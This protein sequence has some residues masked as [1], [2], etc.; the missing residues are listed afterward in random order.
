MVPHRTG[1]ARPLV[2]HTVARTANSSLHALRGRLHD[3]RVCRVHAPIFQLP[4]SWVCRV[5]ASDARLPERRAGSATTHASK[6]PSRRA[7]SQF[8]FP[9][10]AKLTPTSSFPDEGAGSIHGPRSHEARS[11]SQLPAGSLR[12]HCTGRPYY[13]ANSPAPV[14]QT[15]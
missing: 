3:R 6:L 10:S 8:R 5:H 1:P 15:E 13:E 11:T 12:P 4:G 7:P 14:A 9:E 2:R